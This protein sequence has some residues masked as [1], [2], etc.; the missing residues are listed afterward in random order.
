MPL[1]TMDTVSPRAATLRFMST[2]LME[3]QETQILLPFEDPFGGYD[4]VRQNH[5]AITYLKSGEKH[6]LDGPALR[7]RS[8]WQ[9]WYQ[10]GK[11]HRADG[12]AFIRKR[13]RET[14]EKYRHVPPTR[15]GTD[16][17]LGRDQWWE[18][19][20][21]EHAL[22]RTDGP[23][24]RW[25]D[26]AEEWFQRGYRH[27]VGLPAVVA[28]DGL[29]EWHQFSTDKSV[30]A[31]KPDGSIVR[32]I[33][34]VNYF[35]ERGPA[36]ILGN[37]VRYWGS[38]YVGAYYGRR[39]ATGPW[40]EYPDGSVDFVDGG[41]VYHRS[42]T[43]SSTVALRQDGRA[44]VRSMLGASPVSLF[45]GVSFLPF[46]DEDAGF[47]D[48]WRQ[49]PEDARRLY[50]NWATERWDTV[51]GN[52]PYDDESRIRGWL[53]MLRNT[54]SIEK[55]EIRLWREDMKGYLAV[56]LR[57]LEEVLA[58]ELGKLQDVINYAG[59][60]LLEATA[61]LTPESRLLR[62]VVTA[63]SIDQAVPEFPAVDQVGSPLLGPKA[64]PS[65]LRTELYVNGIAECALATLAA[66]VECDGI[67]LA[68]TLLLNVMVDEIDL[69]TGRDKRYCVLSVQVEREEFEALHLERVD[70]LE[71]IRHLG[72]VVPRGVNGLSPVR[73]IIAFDK[74]DARLVAA[75]DVASRMESRANLMDLTPNEFESL[76]QNLFTKIGLDTHQTQA[77][78]DGGVDA[79][80]YDARPIF[81]GKIIIQAKR[82]KNTVGVSAVRDL[83]G[84]VL[85]EGASKG[86][87]VTTSGYGKSSFE[88]AKNKPLEL[89][90]GG[91]LLHLL[92]EHLGMDAVI[93][94]PTTWEDPITD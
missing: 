75:T 42:A 80:A 22:H 17:P 81:G 77:S 68:D 86:L 1:L 54:M 87:L 47:E 79:I 74:E 9:V 40:I 57:R 11:V 21:F 36:V 93:I 60:P 83:Y 67:E 51:Q 78:R 15:S 29:R 24:I 6:R 30:P 50:A 2:S 88:F 71:C 41:E 82:Y 55:E 5:D 48:C 61:Q 33:S 12:P 39:P 56:A 20:F 38:G 4:M 31:F 52:L 63:P 85:N 26:G 46:E 37:R 62:A 45:A 34:N 27:R 64:R 76:I 32:A 28:P 16:S 25:E 72:G 90:E 84:T 23:A 10:A 49:A 66:I 14:A 19:W 69:A 13:S 89:L 43:H 8:G 70:P 7:L 92:K 18:G 35:R 94:P 91:H 65:R 73:P 58:P 53:E 3:E 59:L 44:Y